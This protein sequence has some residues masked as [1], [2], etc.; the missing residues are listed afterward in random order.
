[1]RCFHVFGHANYWDVEVQVK[2]EDGAGDEDDEYGEGRI[3]EVSDLDLHGPEFDAPTDVVIGRGWL[4]AHV[5]PICGLEIF[6]MV[7]FS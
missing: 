7:G 1:M 2:G 6:E 3:F 5:L 4:E